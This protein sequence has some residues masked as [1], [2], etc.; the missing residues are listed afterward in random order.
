MNPEAPEKNDD[1]RRFSISKATIKFKQQP[2][3]YSSLMDS[4]HPRNVHYVINDLFRLTLGN[5]EREGNNLVASLVFFLYDRKLKLLNYL[6]L[7]SL[8]G[9]GGQI[10]PPP[11]LFFDLI[12][13]CLEALKKVIDLSF[14]ANEFEMGK[15]SD[16][17]AE[18]IQNLKD[19]FLNCEISIF[20]NAGGI[21]SH[22]RWTKVCKR[23]K[24]K[25]F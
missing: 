15:E 18:A 13:E 4:R 19:K 16:L 5:E 1:E 6:N 17:I 11:S 12:F 9:E 3:L 14:T 21:L 24:T 10:A 22:F 2:D 7:T 23:K 20:K 25:I 8:R